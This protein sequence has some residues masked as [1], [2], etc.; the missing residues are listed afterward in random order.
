M[1]SD[2][3]RHFLYHVGNAAVRPYPYPHLYL[4]DV[5][6]REY[7]AA[8]R[9]NLPGRT[10]YA[11]LADSGRVTRG[12]YRERSIF[13]FE[14]RDLSKLAPGQA[15]FWRDFAGWFL[16]EEVMGLLIAK[17]DGPIRQRFAD[18]TGNVTLKPEAYLVKD[19]SGYAI[20]PHTDAPHRL[21]SLLL[22]IPA[23]DR[24]QSH[25]TS[26]YAPRDRQFTCAGGPHYKPEPF[27]RIA[28]MPY[29]PN[30][31]FA[32]PKT[33][34]SF[35]GVEP[36]AEDGIERDIILYDVR[37]EGELVRHPTAGNEARA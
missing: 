27:D 13:F 20:G 17:F 16:D 36:I 11:S 1:F 10:D 4:T 34:T 30:A 9:R 26:L 7:F 24:W 2:A 8:M 33:E 32:F 37:L 35:H 6:P 28:T 23:D 3:K 31:L 12:A 22:Y 21:I 15:D 5:L 25:G 29:L 14:D 19:A 18:C